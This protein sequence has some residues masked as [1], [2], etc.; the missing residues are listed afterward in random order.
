MTRNAW[1]VWALRQAVH[2]ETTPKVTASKAPP[3]GRRLSSVD[4]PP[5]PKRAHV[6]EVNAFQTEGVDADTGESIPGTVFGMRSHTVGALQRLGYD[7][8]E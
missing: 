4:G 7:V 3:A 8:I 2:G 1:V 6:V 5:P